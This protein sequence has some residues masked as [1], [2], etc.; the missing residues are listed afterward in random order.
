METFRE[1]LCRQVDVL[2][3]Y[4][5]SCVEGGPVENNQRHSWHDD[6]L[7]ENDGDTESD[8]LLK[9]QAD[10]SHLDSENGHREQTSSFLPDIGIDFKGEAFTFKATTAG[11]L[12][13]LSHCIELMIQREDQ[14]QRRFEKEQ[15]KRKRAE[16]AY[17]N[18]S[19]E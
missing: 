12:A 18:A 1:L 5:D 11:I 10:N 3:A 16:E 15:D 19:A 8:D 14:W 9:P 4:F 7:E 13:T 17:R 6:P 2:Q